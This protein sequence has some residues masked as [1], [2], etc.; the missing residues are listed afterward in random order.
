MTSKSLANILHA[1]VM[2][3]CLDCQ[4]L[5]DIRPRLE[6]LHAAGDIRPEGYRTLFQCT[7]ALGLNSP[8]LQLSQ[9]LLAEARRNW[10]VS[11]EHVL[12][13]KLQREVL[14]TIRELY[15][16][17][18]EGKTP[19]GLFSVDVMVCMGEQQVAVEV[20][21]PSHFSSTE[22]RQPLG[23]TS[24]R[25][26]MLERR[27]SSVVSIPFFEWDCKDED[28]RR[29]YIKGKLIPCSFPQNNA[30]AVACAV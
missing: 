2:L 27:C 15:P 17:Q 29:A 23:A 19:D 24:F 25:R 20:D 28:E 16:C 8:E 1:S 21:G 9:E 30:A 14:K 6:S 4:F 18:E 12:E 22:P 7:L 13:S 26:K 10:L 5:N 11:V 3:G